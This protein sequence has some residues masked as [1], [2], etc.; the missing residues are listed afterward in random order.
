LT[1]TVKRTP[2]GPSSDWLVR[3]VREGSVL[4]VQ[5]PAGG[6]T[7]PSLDGDFLFLAAGSGIAPV[8]S[9][10]KS[11]LAAGTGRAVL[12]YA[13]R[14]ERSVIFAEQLDAL[15]A[16]Y[17]DRFAVVHWLES[18]QGLP[19]PPRLRALAEPFRDREVYACGPG[20]FVGGALEALDG[21][22]VPAARIHLEQFRPLSGGLFPAGTENR[23]PVDA[24]P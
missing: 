5:P 8:M 7:P 10:V 3:G 20:L 18:L 14:D 17:P 1:V 11:V 4:R 12:V 6:F 22:G 16:A 13:N 15:A 19:D 2:N 21:L 23:S 24:I 9:I